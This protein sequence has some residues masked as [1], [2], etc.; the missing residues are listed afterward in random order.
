[1]PHT[2]TIHKFTKEINEIFTFG[3]YPKIA[4]AVSGGSDSLAL[5][6]LSKHWVEKIGGKLVCLT[7][8]HNLR[9]EASEEARYTQKICHNHNIEHHILNWIGT[10]KLSNLQNQAREARR[11]LL[12]EWCNQNNV[13]CLLLA[14][15]QDDLVETFFIRL[16]RGS[17]TQGLASISPLSSHNNIYIIRPLLNFKKEEL[18]Q[19]L[20]LQ[21]IEWV[22]DP[23]N[24]NNKFLRTKIRKLLKSSIMQDIIPYDLLIERCTKGIKSIQNVNDLV[25]IQKNQILTKT[26][27][28][29]PEGFIT[30]DCDSFIKLP[31]ELALNVLSSCLITISATHFYRPRLASLRKIYDNIISKTIKTSTLW[32]CEITLKKNIIYIYPE[33]RNTLPIISIKN[34]NCIKWDNRFIIEKTNV[35]EDHNIQRCTASILKKFQNSLDTKKYKT[36][37]K[38]IFYSLPVLELQDQIY[39]PFLTNHTP[40]EINIYFE[41]SIPLAKTIFSY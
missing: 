3:E 37:P 30:I 16:F 22:Q 29:Y 34:K 10:T 35:S 33:I 17:G 39:V 18:E 21:N 41:P 9:P 26:V 36:L 24:N 27:L 5:A 20:K 40:S 2:T 31:T 32:K 14:H 28:L 8:N 19:Y 15:H 1:M 25:E 4:V 13:K 12:T 7:V 11:D 38:K 23:S 6:L